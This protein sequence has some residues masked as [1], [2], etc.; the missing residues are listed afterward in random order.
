MAKHDWR[1][2]EWSAEWLLRERYR[3]VATRRAVRTRFQSV[4]FFG[5]DCMGRDVEGRTWWIQ[6]TAGKS[7]NVAHRR[8]K[9]EEHQW[10][11]GVML[12]EVR[13]EKEGR[14]KVGMYRLHWW[15][16]ATWE[17]VDVGEVPRHWMQPCH[18][19]EWTR[20]DGIKSRRK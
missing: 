9:I 14:R 16:N 18:R 7:A 20:R 8:R 10:R 15:D 2:A 17:I 12:I 19:R 3:C 6:A 4:D 1:I 11:E 13:L 5:C